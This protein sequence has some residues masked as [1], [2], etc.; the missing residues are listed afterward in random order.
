VLNDAVTPVGRPEAV[1][2]TVPVNPLVGVTVM[3]LVPL[4]PSAM[5]KLA[6]DA[7]RLKSGA[8]TALTLS[9]TVVV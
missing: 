4:D 1:S 5:V 7:E 3:V 8:A 9:E 2:A 6:G